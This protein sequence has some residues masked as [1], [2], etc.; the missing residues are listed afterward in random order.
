ML[1][2]IQW[3]LI[4]I[5]L[6]YL[7]L[8]VLSFLF[9]SGISMRFLGNWG[10]LTGF[11]LLVSAL[12]LHKVVYYGGRGVAGSQTPEIPP[13]EHLHEKAQKQSE[14]PMNFSRFQDS[15][16]ISGIIVLVISFL[17]I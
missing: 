14:K 17:I 6:N 4:I 13:D 10:L 7:L 12:P 1:K 2:R 16:T 11:I 3:I 9:N 5:S 8:I 15:F